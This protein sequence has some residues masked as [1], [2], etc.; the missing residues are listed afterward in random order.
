VA[1][2]TGREELVGARARGR[3]TRRRWLAGARVRHV[4][5]G[6]GRHVGGGTVMGGRPHYVLKV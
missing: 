6:E 5:C 4:S 2:I 3:D 1:G